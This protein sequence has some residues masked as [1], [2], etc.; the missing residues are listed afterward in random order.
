MLSAIADRRS[1]GDKVAPVI[2]LA[3]QLDRSAHPPGSRFGGGRP[4][5]Y[6]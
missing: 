4:L 5:W 2:I 6:Y 3:E 1:A